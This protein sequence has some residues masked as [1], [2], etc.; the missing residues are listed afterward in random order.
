M[1][2]VNAVV[3]DSGVLVSSPSYQIT[4]IAP[5][6]TNVFTTIG[7]DWGVADTMLS[8]EQKEV[9]RSMAVTIG[10]NMR[11]D[12][13]K[14]LFGIDVLVE[15]TT[16]TL[17]LIEI[18]ARQPASTTYESMLQRMEVDR[19][20]HP[21]PCLSGRQAPLKK[22]REYLI[23]TFEAH[24]ATLLDLD[25]SGYSLIPVTSGAQIIQRITDGITDVGEEVIAEMENLGCTV[26][27]YTNTKIGSEL[28]R[29]QSEKSMMNKHNLLDDLGQTIAHILQRAT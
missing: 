9:I 5:F 26:R 7:N 29:I 22:G 12:G 8:A 16:G 3:H 24:L 23:T 13:W 4:G 20:P 6:T 18:N 17:Y 21:N 28:L 15:E 11:R 27:K 10:E 19:Q 2:T 25:L 1:Y 14:G